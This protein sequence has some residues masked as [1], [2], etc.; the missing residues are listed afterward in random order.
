M[1]FY[2]I[3]EE[4]QWEMKAQGEIDADCEDDESIFT[5]L[6][7]AVR[8]AEETPM[9]AEGEDTSKANRPS[10]LDEALQGIPDV[11]RPDW[12][13]EYDEDRADC[14]VRG[15]DAATSKRPKAGRLF[16]AI[17]DSGCGRS[18]APTWLGR[19]RNV[20][21]TPQ[22]RRGHRSRARAVPQQRAS[23]R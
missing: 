10:W 3:A 23:G 9:D 14:G 15:V 6:C 13:A 5:D 4:A 18:C 2:D 20:E 11:P 17:M 21:E 7:G 22:S 1:V 19:G 12:L 8:A 16:A